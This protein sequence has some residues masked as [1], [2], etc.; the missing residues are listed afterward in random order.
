MKQLIFACLS[1]SL[2]TTILAQSKPEPREA[3]ASHTKIAIKAGVNTSTARVYQ[4]DE[5]LESKFV[6]G[7]GIAILFKSPFEGILHFSPTL[8]YNRRGY[9]YTPKSGTITEYTNTI[10]YFDMVPALSF[11]FPLGVNSF[12]ISAGPHISFAIAGTEKT[13]SGTTSSTSKMNFDLSKDYGYI[14]MGLN[15]SI[16]FHMKKFL[17]EAG[18]QLG[19][20]NINNNVETDFRNIQNRM[21]SLQLGYYFK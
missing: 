5:Q 6:S 11:D 12:V 13:I 7:Y 18:F 9:T 16:G 20:T 8:G 17:L 4:N 14:D 19:L 10:H 2:S 15:G 21:I 1:I 3:P